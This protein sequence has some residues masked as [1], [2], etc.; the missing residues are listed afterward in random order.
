M[1]PYPGLPALYLAHPAAA[2]VE[3][4]DGWYL[5]FEYDIE[6]ERGLDFSEDLFN[7]MVLRLSL[8]PNAAAPLI[9][10]TV[11][12][13]ADEA[14]AMRAHE[15]ARR[16][17][18]V[19]AAPMADPTASPATGTAAMEGTTPTAG[20]FVER[21]TA[22]ADA[23]LVQRGEL[24]TVI[25]GYHW[26]SDWGRDTMIALPGLTLV[27]GR[28]EAARRI[29]LAFAASVDQGMLP[30]RFPD[31]GEAPEYNTVDATLWFFEAVRAYGEAAGDDDFLRQS[32]FPVLKTIVDWHRRGTRYGIHADEDGLL[33]CGEPGT[34]LTW[35]DARVNGEAVT[36]R[37]GKP[38]E[39]Q[40]LWYNALRILQAMAARFDDRQSE[41]SLGELADRALRN[42]A[43]QFWNQED[44]C[45]FDVV[46]GNERDAAIRPNQ[47][48]ALSLPHRILEDE[49][50]SR[51]VLDVV[52]RELFTPAGIRTL[53]PRDSRY[54]GRYEGGVAS[55]DGAYH[56]GTVW[57]WLLGPFVT[58]YRK[59]KG[60]DSRVD[61][62][63]RGPGSPCLGQF[64]EIADGDA[65]HTP[66]GC[67]AQAWS[68]GELL[69][70]AVGRQ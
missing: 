43:E 36:P 29:L 25:A 58:A 1:R 62:W 17:A 11:P 49:A 5:N 19:A 42:F 47:L 21:L 4:G 9:A 63:L 44:G 24:N 48:F 56:Q 64:A 61:G 50:R 13:D 10:S 54:R 3:P 20:S 7:P 60:D 27:T 35:M 39:I 55:R 68:V 28:H 46:N 33:A 52:E 37:I 18:I 66:R 32:M 2:A 16:T 12:H 67:V 45:L 8:T 40:A 59:V 69:R 14:A 15:I 41:A 6:R 57:P 51:S 70:A 53:S 26:F 30:N 31:G 22:A 65:P 38:V 34:Q 23:F